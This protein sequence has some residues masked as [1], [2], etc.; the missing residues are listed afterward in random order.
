MN[1]EIYD[2][3]IAGA[4][5]AGCEAGWAAAKK[6]LKILLITPNLDTIG[7]TPCNPAIGGPGKSQI[8]RELDALGGLMPVVTD[9]TT[10]HIRMLNTSAGAAV[11]SL[12][13]QIDRALYRKKVKHML[14]KNPNIFI[15][16]DMVDDIIIEN[17]KFSRVL[18]R[19]KTEFYGKKLIL[20][21]GTFLG[22]LVHIGDVSYKAGRYGEAGSYN[23]LKSL[24]SLGIDTFTLKTGTTPRISGK[25]INQSILEK[26]PSEKI[27]TPFSYWQENFPKAEMDCFITRTNKDVHEIIK[28]NSH[29]SPMFKGVIKGTGPRYCPS[30]EDKVIRF[31][32]KDSHKIFLEPEGLDNDEYYMQGFSTSLPEDVQIDMIK[33][34]KGLENVHIYKPGYAVEYAAIDSTR[35]FQTLEHKNLKGIYFAGQINGT[36]GYEEAAAQGLVAG[37]NAALSINGEPEFILSREESYIGTLIDDLITRGT[38]EPYRMF[39]SRMD[40]RM[41]VRQDNAHIRL[42]NQAYKS[43]LININQYEDIENSKERV[44]QAVNKI[45][46]SHKKMLTYGEVLNMENALVEEFKLRRDEII[47]VSCELIYSGYILKQQKFLEMNKNWLEKKIP[48]NIEYEKILN[49]SFEARQ[50][51]DKIKPETVGHAARIPGINATDITALIFFIRKNT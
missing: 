37:I 36:S 7:E 11:H 13:A 23:L 30:I 20:T 28:S 2:I 44:F 14:E 35:L 50:K 48:V 38:N 33:K 5:H 18:T 9:M 19:N 41:S 10:I 15:K 45:K 24:A 27:N 29:R 47:T 26:Q 43:G 40:S 8:V 31:F 34:I 39:T 4:G 32:S 16:Q 17:G 25:T 46:N 42:F 51:L 22:G 6:N 1:T 12:R 21:P 49:L 3:I